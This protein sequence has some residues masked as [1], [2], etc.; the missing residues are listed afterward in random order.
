MHSAIFRKFCT[1]IVHLHIHLRPVTFPTVLP[2][3][4]PFFRQEILL[5]KL[6]KIKILYV[7]LQPQSLGKGYIN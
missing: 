5:I 6:L 3:V 1:I 7:Y 4:Q 2:G